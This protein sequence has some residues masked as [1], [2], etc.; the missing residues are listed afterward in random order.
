MALIE[1]LKKNPIIYK[2]GVYMSIL[3]FDYFVDSIDYIKCVLRKLK[4]MSPSKFD[5]IRNLRGKYKGKR[6]FIIATGPSLTIN[7]LDS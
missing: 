2:I 5:N 1:T 3:Y 7:D 4:I 6:C